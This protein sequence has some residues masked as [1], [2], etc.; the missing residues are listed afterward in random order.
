MTKEEFKTLFERALEVAARNAETKLGRAVPRS[1]EIELRGLP[2]HPN[3]LT[4]DEAV[5]KIYIG[6]DRFFLIIN[7]G[8]IRVSPNTCTVVL[9][10]S[11]HAPG[12]FGRT[13][14]Q[15]VGTGPFQQVIYDEIKVE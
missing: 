9:G 11:G 2:P 7:V 1:I 13:W 14:N 4:V 12:E 8:V 10:P 15:P 5:D 3:I 6:P